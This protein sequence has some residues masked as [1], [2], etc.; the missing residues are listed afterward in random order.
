MFEIIISFLSEGMIRQIG[1]RS[2]KDGE[3]RIVVIFQIN[4]K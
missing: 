3:I 4:T 2:A 1:H